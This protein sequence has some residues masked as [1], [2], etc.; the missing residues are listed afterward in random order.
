MFIFKYHKKTL[1][2][3]I[4]RKGDIMVEDIIK[5]QNSISI[6]KACTEQRKWTDMV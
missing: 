1:Q 5:V 3:I 4:Q 6:T 2:L